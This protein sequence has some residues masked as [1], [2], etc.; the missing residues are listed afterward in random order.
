[1]SMKKYY[2]GIDIGT[3][4]VKLVAI[5]KSGDHFSSKCTYD[6]PGIENYCLA[7]R[8]ALEMLGR[9]LPLEQVSAIGLSSQ[10][11]TYLTDSGETIPWFSNAG[12]AELAEVK[13]ICSDE[14]F[15]SEIGMCHPDLISYPLPR[16]LYVKRNFPDATSVIMPKEAIIRELTGRLVTD[17]FS[18]RGICDPQTNRYSEKLLKKLG[19]DLKLPDIVSPTDIAGFITPDAAKRYSLP[20]GTPVYTG[21]NDFYAGLLG[22]GVVKEGTFF[23]LSGTSEHIGVI[24]S[25]LV[26][27]NLISGK[28]FSGYATYGGT[29]ASGVACDFAINNFGIGNLDENT[30]IHKQPIFLPYMRGE[31][32][33]VFDENAK[34]VFFGIT[35]E[36]TKD[37]MAY[38]VLEGVV[39]SLY[40]ISKALPLNTA[41]QI[42]TGGGSTADRLMMKL[43]AS[44]FGCDIV[45]AEQNESSAV[46]AA[47]IAMVGSKEFDDFDAA[48]SAVIRY[49][50]IMK[51]DP[52]VR[53]RLLG[54]FEIYEKLYPCLKEQFDEFSK[55]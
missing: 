8:S 35:D 29:K 37:D 2:L 46:G 47:M 50:S 25:E 26:R 30:V 48:A 3:S 33:P 21:C 16:L 12:E 32:A 44:L 54:R 11:G 51:P 55:I 10:V 1:M 49:D 5:D 31:R 14:E 20:I 4:S 22:M 18:Q 41:G 40:H 52:L 36:T 43:K 39:F 19:I 24:T 42:I 53:D 15:M 38:S 45:H 28:Y 27:G 17:T 7:L 9:E 13:S 34:G 23:E 6:T